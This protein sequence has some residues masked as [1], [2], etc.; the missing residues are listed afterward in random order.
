[1][2]T[3]RISLS[4]NENVPRP[5]KKFGFPQTTTCTP[6]TSLTGA[7]STKSRG[8]VT[9][10]DMSA[11]GSRSTMNTVLAPGRMLIWVN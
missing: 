6:S 4:R 11:A 2:P 9:V 8:A 5:V 1:M 3:A 10:S 7:R